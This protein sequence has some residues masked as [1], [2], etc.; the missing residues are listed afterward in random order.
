LAV[1][2]VG[3]GVLMAPALARAQRVTKVPSGDKIVVEGVGEVR[4]LGVT[5]LDES[6]FGVGDAPVAPP[7][8]DPPE[9]TSNPP[10][11]FNGRLKFHP[12]RPSRDFLKEAALGKTIR[13]QYDS[14]VENKATRF[15]YVFL[16]DGTLLNAEMVKRGKAKVDRSRPFAHEEEFV[17]LEDAARSAGLGVW[18][19]K[20]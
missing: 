8:H 1:F 6:P 14:L 20:R 19:S 16:P 18:A 7:R 2:L 9:P 4:L 10:T 12:N 5:S 15:A 3:V 17:Q 13:L 11:V